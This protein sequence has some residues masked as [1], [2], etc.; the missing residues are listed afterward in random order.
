MGYHPI[1]FPLTFA[2]SHSPAASTHLTTLAQ[3]C[4]NLITTYHLASIPSSTNLLPYAVGN[5]VW[6]EGKH[7]HL[8]YPSLKLT[9][10][11]FGPFL[12]IVQIN[13]VTFKLR[14]SPSWNTCIH[15]V[16][17]ASLLSPYRVD[18]HGAHFMRFFREFIATRARRA[19][20]V[21]DAQ[22]PVHD[23]HSARLTCNSQRMQPFRATC[24]H[25]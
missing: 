13:P 24:A 16:F 19:L 1:A 4:C 20:G 25:S 22:F 9:P 17:H 3:L 15:P 2:S 7:L 23:M 12:I 6:L 18:A 5:K 8:A 14:L 11:H 21:T 10:R